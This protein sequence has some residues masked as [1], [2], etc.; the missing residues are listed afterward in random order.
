VTIA[1]PPAA[2]G[3]PQYIQRSYDLTALTATAGFGDTVGIVDVGVGYTQLESDLSEYRSQFALPPCTSASGC[4]RIVGQDGSSNVPAKAKGQ[5]ANWAFETAMDVDAVSTTCPNCHI[6][7]VEA[8]A[9]TVPDYEAAEL[10]ADRLGANQISNSWSEFWSFDKRDFTFPGVAV[11]AASGDDGYLGGVYSTPEPVSFPGVTAVGGTELMQAS[12]SSPNARG[13]VETGWGGAS[14]ACTSQP[15]PVWQAGD[16]TGCLTRSVADISADADGSTGLDVFCSCDSALAGYTGGGTSL[17][18]ALVA[19]YYGLL[20]SEGM[21][22][23]EGGAAWAYGDAKELNAITS[24][25][26][27]STNGTCR[28]TTVCNESSTGNYSGITGVGS[29]SGAVIAGPPGVAGGTGCSC[30]EGTAD[31]VSATPSPTSVTL[32]GG[33]YPNQ[34]DTRYWWEYGPTSAYGQTTTPT[35]IGAGT[36]VVGVTDTITGLTPGVDYHFALVASNS[37]G[38]VS[39]G[40]DG[41]TIDSAIVPGVLS[42]KV[43]ITSAPPATTSKTGGWVAFSVTGSTVGRLTCVLDAKRT[44]CREGSA[45][46]SHLSAGR[47]L[48]VITATGPGGVSSTNATWTVKTQSAA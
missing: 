31:Y 20:H 26:N 13:V 10:T 9:E 33:V 4:L 22:A 43:T 46:F 39:D 3:S 35:D 19:G 6:L 18:T 32:S 15:Q 34:L 30:A 2:F 47:H 1:E 16:G 48:M 23:G 28:T 40:P 37:A 17:A 38:T 12:P 24:G 8:A 41:T 27:Y 14:S 44:P 36:A 21:D 45:R 5:N 11:L 29:I 42:P 25:S 7:V